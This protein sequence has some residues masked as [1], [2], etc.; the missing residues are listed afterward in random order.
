MSRKS[1]FSAFLLLVLLFPGTAPAGERTALVWQ[2]GDCAVHVLED[3]PGRMDAG[4]FSGPA[5]DAERRALFDEDGKAA[6]SISVFLIRQDGKNILVDAGFGDAAPGAS[7]LMPLL[8]SMDITPEQIDAV[9]LTHMHIDHIGGLL[10]QGERAFPRA[11]VLVSSPELAFW[12]GADHGE[13]ARPNAELAR[14]VKQAYGDDVRV[15]AFGEEPLPGISGL[16]S[17]GHTPGHT[18]FRV[19]NRDKGK[20]LLII[21]DLIH[22]A[23]LQFPLPEECALYDMDREKAVAARRAVLE[24]AASEELLTAGMHLPWPGAGRVEKAGRG[25]GFAPLKSG[26]R[27]K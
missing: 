7:A 13:G 17:S 19:K 16:D 5:T 12:L 10:L 25:F 24:L 15:F 27:E 21:G 1:L 14:R 20:D 3:R 11:A 23:A 22:A 8:A 2:S 26:A 6:A 9:L 4:L 18:V